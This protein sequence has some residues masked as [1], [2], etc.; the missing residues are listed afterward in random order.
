MYVCVR[1]SSLGPDDSSP[2]CVKG[3]A[4]QCHLLPSGRFLLVGVVSLEVYALLDVLTCK[5]KSI[6][7]IC[8]DSSTQ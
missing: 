7:I 3:C 2:G 8:F 6:S 5:L 4:E 1:D